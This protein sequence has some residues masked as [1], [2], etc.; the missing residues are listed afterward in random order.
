M[1]C[2]ATPI[3]TFSKIP[4]KLQLY[5][6][7]SNNKST[8]PIVGK[9]ATT[10]YNHISVVVYRNN[11][12]YKYLK[13]TLNYNN[14]SANFA[15]Y[16][17][18]LSELAEYKF[19][20]YAKRSADSSLIASR[21]SIV[22]GDVYVINGQSNSHYANSMETYSNQYCRTFGIQTN[23]SNY[24]A[25]NPRDTT[26][27]IAKGVY[28]YLTGS[29]GIILQKL[30]RDNHGIP[31]CIINGGTGGSKIDEHFKNSIQ[32]DYFT[33]TIYGKLHY[34]LL[35]SGLIN[36]I[37][38]IFWYQ[39]ERDANNLFSVYEGYFQQLYQSWKSDYASAA[40]IYL[41]Q[42]NLGCNSN[43]NSGKFREGQRRFKQSYADIHTIATAGIKGYDGCHYD[44]AGYH[45][46][47]RQVYK[48]V[49]KD[50]YN[51]TDTINIQSPEIKRAYYASSRQQ[52]I[53]LEFNCV[54]DLVWSPSLGGVDLKDYFYIDGVAGKVVS[55][56]AGKNKIILQL[57]TFSNATNI[58][59]L[60]DMVSPSTP[61]L[62]PTVKSIRGVN[63]FSFY[64]F[65][66]EPAPLT[67]L[68]GSCPGAFGP[69]KHIFGTNK[70]GNVGNKITSNTTWY[71]DSI[72]VL[73]RYVRV[74]SGATLTIQPG[75]I[76]MGNP[77]PKD[78]SL[79]LI[80]KG[81]KINAIGTSALPIVFTSCK[82][83]GLRVRGDWGGVV[84]C[85][86]APN[87]K[88]TNLELEGN[89]NAIHGGNV[90]SDNSGN[91]QYVRIEYAGMA[92]EPNKEIN[93]LTLASVGSGTTLR[94]IQVSFSGDDSFE[95]F[96]GT[97][98]GKYLISWKP[99]D[100]DFDTDNGYKGYNQ[101]G[102]GFRDPEIADQSGSSGFESDNDE[103]G[104]N[105][106]PK[107][108]PIFSNFEVWGPVQTS[109]T[110]IN[111]YFIS[112]A[113]L[114]K[115]TE[116]KLFNTLFIAWP[117]DSTK[118]QS[119]GIHFVGN[120]TVTNA[121]KDSIKVRNC[122]SAAYLP[123][124]RT[125]TAEPYL[126]WAPFASPTQ[127]YNKPSNKD[128]V[129]NSVIAVGKKAPFKYEPLFTLNANSRVAKGSS[130]QTG[131]LPALPAFF[132]SV[133]YRGAFGGTDW[134]ASWTE[135][136]P[137]IFV[138]SAGIPSRQAAIQ[139]KKLENAE[140]INISYFKCFPN[141]TSGYATIEVYIPNA[142]GEF[143]L[144]GFDVLGLNTFS[145][146]IY[147]AEGRGVL[148]LDLS[149][150]SKGIHILK[151]KNMDKI[152]TS[153]IILKD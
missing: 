49:S 68:D 67:G 91:M 127:W 139:H 142:N 103:N 22:S 146:K 97:V 120:S 38:A 92:L 25:Y 52:Q 64:E 39:G 66:L 42:I 35:K 30:I 83:Q 4:A 51:A 128:S 27:N 149:N 31:T 34:R 20:I 11:V 145:E 60:P 76:I 84:I 87:N 102:L 53:V 21:D 99:L 106:M 61:F 134:T 148:T 50:F 10:G 86:N 96:G 93:G 126:A 85:G 137:Q 15:L 112:G 41:F 143:A 101:Y 32:S 43:S 56:L 33:N 121:V 1:L 82:L 73:H 36:D 132:Q 59:Y 144:E 110:R 151:I 118:L 90:A 123:N 54:S 72:Y 109:E 135:F 69:I 17:T 81:G 16:P 70:E 150:K 105:A 48:I 130:F 40:K 45:E 74:A 13:A 8:I 19:D 14:G 5:P 119:S 124:I 2:C 98:N 108:A 125:G 6:R 133:N 44:T 63:A 23:N 29:W 75:T 94:Y 3:V 65:P 28:P 100:D 24:V 122:V 12:F 58:T 140:T 131:T 37:K 18:I 114:Q 71:K 7:K 152:Y 147:C 46:M 78:T 57:D 115:N 88:G 80:E 136:H 47:A 107:T 26:W 77:A 111:P 55:G 113:L 129:I 62:G 116:I 141:P 89:Y 138:Y 104:S 153:K 117:S 95:W 79:L 9:I